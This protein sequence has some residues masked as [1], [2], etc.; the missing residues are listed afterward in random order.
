VRSYRGQNA[1]LQ[2]R[3]RHSQIDDSIE[4]AADILTKRLG[5][6]F[7][8]SFLTVVIRLHN[9]KVF[10]IKG[11]RDFCNGRTWIFLASVLT[12]SAY[13]AYIADSRAGSLPFC[14]TVQ[15]K[16]SR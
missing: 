1:K 14:S 7:R 12:C 11:Q 8:V 9:P 6:Q 10:G 4:T 15:T 3:L 16:G 13:T 2:L 5:Q